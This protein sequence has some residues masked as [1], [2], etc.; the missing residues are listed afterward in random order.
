MDYAQRNKI[1]MHYHFKHKHAHGE[2]NQFRTDDT[3]VFMKHFAVRIAAY[4]INIL[5]DYVMHVV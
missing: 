4:F 3:V 5:L 1:F 2:H